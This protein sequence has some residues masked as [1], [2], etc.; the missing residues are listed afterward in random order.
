MNKGS[1]ECAELVFNMVQRAERESEHGRA[2][3]NKNCVN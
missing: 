2:G 3:W 1:K